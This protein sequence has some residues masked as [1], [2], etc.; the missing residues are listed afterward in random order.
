MHA[1]E[2]G[3]A[4][5]KGI[6]AVCLGCT[7]ARVVITK[8]GVGSLA[9][10]GVEQSRPDAQVTEA[11][12]QTGLQDEDAPLEAN[13]DEGAPDAD[14]DDG[15]DADGEAPSDQKVVAKFLVSNA[16][17]GSVIGKGGSNIAGQWAPACRCPHQR[18]RSACSCRMYSGSLGSCMVKASQTPPHCKYL[19][20][21]AEFQTQSSA[22]IQLSRANE[23]F[24][25]TSDRVMLIS[26]TVGQVRP[27]AQRPAVP[28]LSDVLLTKASMR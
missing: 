9:A 16:A 23:Y 17:A 3:A 22:R 19:M 18:M 14:D 26:G 5:L 6:P 21:R 20:P 1:G 15:D 13:G 12:A 25:G 2:S 28:P 4:F 11:L 27:A 8:W 7:W 10:T 24:P